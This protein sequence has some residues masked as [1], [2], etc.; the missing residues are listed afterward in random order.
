LDFGLIKRT[1][2]TERVNAEFRAEFF[3]VFN[4]VNFF[5][6]GV[7]NINSTQFGRI[8]SAFPARV[9]QFALKLNF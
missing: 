4:N 9:T 6:G 7:Q 3:N 2:L 1:N 5:V 8:T